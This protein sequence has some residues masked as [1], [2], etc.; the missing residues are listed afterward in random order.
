MTRR[1]ELLTRTAFA[2]PDFL[3]RMVRLTRSAESHDVRE[4]L[5]E[6]ICPVLLISSDQD[7]ITPME[8]QVYLREHIQNAQHL[9]FPKTGHAAFYERPDLFVSVMM[10]WFNHH[11][12]IQLP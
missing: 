2:N 6:I 1:K 9:V 5:G 3:A 10:G 11:A 12:T 8:E 4:R 7:H